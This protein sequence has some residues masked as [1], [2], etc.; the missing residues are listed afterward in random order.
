MMKKINI[1]SFDVEV[2]MY[3]AFKKICETK[4]IDKVE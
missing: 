4:K 1:E 3:K 2:N